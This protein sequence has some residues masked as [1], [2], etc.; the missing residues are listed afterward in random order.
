MTVTTSAG[1]RSPPLP[2]KIYALLVLASVVYCAPL[3]TGTDLWGRGDWDQFGFRYATPRVAMLRDLQLPLWNPY[4]NGGTVLLAH[5]HCPAFSPWYLPTLI[6]GA[7]LG[8][9]VQVLLFVALGATGMAALLRR[10]GVSPA[11]C[12]VGGVLLM[13]SAHFAM[14]VAEGHLEWCLLGLMPWVL[15]CLLCA[16]QVGNPPRP[17]S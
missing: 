17:Q 14:H 7:P 4:V 10:W 5:P 9:R 11:G 15:L 8:L 1:D 3:L 6:L 16:L 12:F 13:M 2:W